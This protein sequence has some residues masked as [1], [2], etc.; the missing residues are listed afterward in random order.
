[1]VP[2]IAFC[3]SDHVKHARLTE[4]TTRKQSLDWLGHLIRS[5][6]LRVTEL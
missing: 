6:T 3:V 1:M 5:W 2:Q 4:A